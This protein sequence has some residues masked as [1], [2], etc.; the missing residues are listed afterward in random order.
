MSISMTYDEI[1]QIAVKQ[2]DAF[3]D[4]YKVPMSE[5]RAIKV[6][7]AKE[8]YSMRIP[9]CFQSYDDHLVATDC[10]PFEDDRHWFAWVE[11]ESRDS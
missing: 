7:M 5:L 3:G 10:N 9:I 4:W 11:Q 2:R 1:H 8:L 6:D